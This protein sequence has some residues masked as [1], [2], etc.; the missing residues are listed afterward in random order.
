VSCFASHTASIYLTAIR[1]L[2]LVYEKGE[3]ETSRVCDVRAQ[4]KDQITTL[5]F[6][7]RLWQLFRAL[8]HEVLDNFR[9]KTGEAVDEIM[10]QIDRRISGFFIQALQL[11]EFTLKMEYDY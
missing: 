6:G 9:Q 1:Y 7:K 5:D 2:M 4:V 3:N 8:I 10:E 11:D